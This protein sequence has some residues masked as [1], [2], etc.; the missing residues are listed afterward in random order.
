[1]IVN[2]HACDKKFPQSDQYAYLP[3]RQYYCS[4][5]C[6]DTEF[7]ECIHCGQTTMPSEDSGWNEDGSIPKVNEC[8][9]C[10]LKTRGLA[11]AVIS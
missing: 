5:E 2:C 4:S 6:Y 7:V 1:M 9:S 10:Y 11:I 8:Q 3:G